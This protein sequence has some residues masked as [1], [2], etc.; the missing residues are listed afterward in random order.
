MEE[1]R[2]LCPTCGVRAGLEDRFCPR[3]GTTLRAQRLPVLYQRALPATVRGPAPAIVRHALVFAAGAL[4]PVLARGA[5]RLA[6]RSLPL[7][8]AM[9]TGHRNGGR[10][11][12]LGDGPIHIE[13]HAIMELRTFRS[14]YFDR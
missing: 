7:Q 12:P 8:R 3:C 5:I 14:I 11:A 10:V 6:L 13:T 9:L 1:K 2:M 4:V